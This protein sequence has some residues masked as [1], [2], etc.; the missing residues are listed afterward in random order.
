MSLDSRNM[1]SSI[2]LEKAFESYR[3]TPEYKKELAERKKTLQVLWIFDDF[4]DAL[5]VDSVETGI[6]VSEL[7]EVEDEILI[8][9][10]KLSPLNNN[11]ETII[12][13]TKRASNDRMYWWTWKRAA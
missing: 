11:V 7:L 1:D 12:D 8:E 4:V 9:N 6:K 5:A 10:S 2:N 3:E 13:L